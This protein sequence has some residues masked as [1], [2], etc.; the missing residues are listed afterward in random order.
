MRARPA[1]RAASAVTMRR[2]MALPAL[3]ALLSCAPASPPAAPGL[4]VDAA[5]CTAQG[6]AIA[7]GDRFGTHTRRCVTPFTDA[8]RSCTDGD[9]CA[10]RCL[11][12]Y[13][14]SAYSLA[15]DPPA[16]EAA[17]RCEAESGTLGC[18]SEVRNGRVMRPVCAD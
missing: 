17:G 3:A 11:F 4:R 5:A 10:G 7:G 9:Q 6:G 2:M 15:G 18:L 12:D 14:G 8:G 13:R 16:G 1:R